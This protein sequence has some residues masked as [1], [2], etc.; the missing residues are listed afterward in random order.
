[1][2]LVSQENYLKWKHVFVNWSFCKGTVFVYIQ[3]KCVFSQWILSYFEI[4]NYLTITLTQSYLQ[5]KKHSPNHIKRPMN[6]FMVFSHI[7]RKKIV[8]LNPDIHNAEISKQLGKRSVILVLLIS[9][10]KNTNLVIFRLVTWY[11]LVGLCILCTSCKKTFLLIRHPFWVS[12]ECLKRFVT[13]I[14]TGSSI[15]GKGLSIFDDTSK[16]CSKVCKCL[17]FTQNK[18]IGWAQEVV[19]M[20]HNC[21]ISLL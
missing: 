9:V 3:W 4:N 18:S 11:I 1:M 14:V 17:I 20:F 13:Y 19:Y 8:E 16:V 5:T 15:V 6:A 12:G 21:K 10:A 2:H 7:E